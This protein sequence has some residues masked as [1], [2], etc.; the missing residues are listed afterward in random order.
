MTGVRSESRLVRPF[1]GLGDA[2]HALDDARIVL[3]PD[4]DQYL[5]PAVVLPP[6]MKGE[7][8]P[9]ILVGDLP[10]RLA[11]AAAAV[12]TEMIRLAAIGFRGF[13]RWTSVFADMSLEE[14]ADGKVELHAEK[15]RFLVRALPAQI[16]VALYLG[17]TPQR[18]VRGLPAR[19][20][21]WIASKTFD[22]DEVADRALFPI[23]PLPEEE[24]Q[25]RGFPRKA[26]LSVEVLGSIIGE[27]G[28]EDA[29][30]RLLLHREA[31]RRIIGAPDAAARAMK[32]ILIADAVIAVLDECRDEIAEAEADDVHPRSVLAGLLRKLSRAGGGE[33]DFPRLRSAIVDGGEKRRLL[34]AALHAYAE[35]VIKISR[36]P[37]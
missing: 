3:V 32:G 18:A 25:R 36:V 29:F 6:E 27:A 33:W 30:A 1:F 14:I 19:K 8:A 31:C 17:A 24:W 12:P 28:A 22:F 20:G 9:S 4:G 23:I 26:L 5:G 37:R 15:A 10:G 11:C 35:A 13:P 7:I 21:H 34:I 16:R 2:A